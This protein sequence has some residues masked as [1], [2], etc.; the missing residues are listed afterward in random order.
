MDGLQSAGDVALLVDGGAV[1]AAVEEDFVGI[2]SWRWLGRGSLADFGSGGSKCMWLGIEPD[3]SLCL[4]LRACGTRVGRG[5][6]AGA[7]AGGVVSES[8]TVNSYRKLKQRL[9][10]YAKQKP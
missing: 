8:K 7:G 4:R 3:V 6:G 2:K 10:L 9:L 5:G 1:E